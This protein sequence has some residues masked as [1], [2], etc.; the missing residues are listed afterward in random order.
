LVL[1]NLISNYC[2]TYFPNTGDESSGLF[3]SKI[4]ANLNL[5]AA[6]PPLPFFFKGHYTEVLNGRWFSQYPPLFSLMIAPGHWLGGV[7]FWISIYSCLSLFIIFQIL[8]ELEF[9]KKLSLIFCI[10]F[11][12]S[13]SYLF[14]SASLYNHIGEF[15]FYLLG[16]LFFIK[17]LKDEQRRNLVLVGLF[18]SL[19]F[20]IRPYTAFLLSLPLLG[21]LFSQI[22][23]SNKKWQGVLS[24]GLPFLAIMSLLLLYNFNQRH[25]FWQI[26]YLMAGDNSGKLGFHNLSSAGF[27][28]FGQMIYDT[29][30]W[31]FPFGYFENG[32]LKYALD[33]NFNLGALLMPLSMFYLFYQ[34]FNFKN[35]WNQIQQKFLL[36]GLLSIF[37]LMLGHLFY[38]ASGGRY[39]E[40]YFFEIT[41]Y[42]FLPGLLLVHGFIE[43]RQNFALAFG[44]GVMLLFT[45]FYSFNTANFFH[46]ANKL[47]MDPYLKTAGLKEAA[48]LVFLEGVPEFDPAFYTL[49]SPTLEGAVFAVSPTLYAGQIKEGKPIDIMRKV[50]KDLGKQ[51]FYLYKYSHQQKKSQLRPMQ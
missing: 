5:T 15:L 8:Q 37:L 16:M 30:Q 46:Q 34:S 6:A 24:L 27:K 48:P 29:G 7:N 25:D 13:P 18:I 50:A 38:D 10:L 14:Y 20:G 40:R 36:V 39:G 35:K 9:S 17:Y 22:F 43:K 31:L 32:N 47:R 51:H 21:I 11:S 12:I 45:G 41:W 44:S 2:L 49:N 19:Q 3:Q 23:H 1:V 26:S 33:S 42:L 28:R 4:F